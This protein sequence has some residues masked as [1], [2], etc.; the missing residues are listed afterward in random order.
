MHILHRTLAALA[1]ATAAG[2]ATAAFPER[3]ITLVVP[4]SAGGAADAQSRLVA[5]KLGQRLGQQ[6][7]VENK[8]GASGTIGA[9]AVARAN[10]DGYTLL[11]DATAHAVNPILYP[12]LSYDSKR[13]FRPLTLVSLTPNL[14]VVPVD[15]PYRTVAD[16]TAAARKQ[17]GHVNY[18]SPGNGTAQHIAAALYAQQSGIEITHIPYKGG[19][20]A[21]TDLVG[22]QVD[23]MFS[24]MAAS[25]PLVRANKLRA[26]ATT[27]RARVDALPDLP[28][29]AET[30]L[31]GY[32]VYEWNGIF[33]PA[34]VPDAIAGQLEQALRAAMQDPSLQASLK[35]LGAQPIGSSAQAFGAFVAD[36]MRRAETVLANSGIKRD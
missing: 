6:I 27:S 22:G 13:D 23:M 25:Y 11:Y 2:A 30:G 34:G 14:L 24:N 35:E 4:Y 9:A 1:L 32:E 7:V 18:A 20:P 15:S 12:S 21:L 33:A 5:A 10:A 17:P 26:L 3:P 31:K 28:T 19:A 36:E 29:V 8:P 16:L